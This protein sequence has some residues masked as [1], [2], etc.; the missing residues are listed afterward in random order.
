[1]KGNFEYF[2]KG[3]AVISQLKDG[4]KILML[5]N[6]SHQNSCEDI[7]RFKIPEWLRKYTGKQLE[8]DM[9]QALDKPPRT[10]NNY[11]L[12]IQCGGCMVTRKQLQNR[13][14]FIIEAGVPITNYGMAI[15]YTHG[16][17]E[18]ATEIF[19]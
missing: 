9:A 13:I 6:C 3:T 10:I 17:F 1:M 2:L 4:D 8:F 7:G 11:A 15:A 18:R 12:A 16:I 19:K 5:E 14:K